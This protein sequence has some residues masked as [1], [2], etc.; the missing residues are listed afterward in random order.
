[1]TDILATGMLK[2]RALLDEIHRH[3]P[4]RTGKL[5][6]RSMAEVSDAEPISATA[7][8][9]LNQELRA[10]GRKFHTRGVSLHQVLRNAP[11]D[12]R[13]AS[14]LAAAWDGIGGLFQ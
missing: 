2:V 8:D 9:R 5:K 4:K 13:D 14:V 7:R 6:F 12:D 3:F 1:M 10:L 11:R